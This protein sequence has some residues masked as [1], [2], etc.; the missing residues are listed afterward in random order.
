MAVHHK[1]IA[2]G[3]LALHPAITSSAEQALER[4][5][6][7]LT[8]SAAHQN[9]AQQ[10]Y[11]ERRGMTIMFSFFTGKKKNSRR[12]SGSD[13]HS[14]NPRKPPTEPEQL[15]YVLICSKC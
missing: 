15:V 10:R 11:V 8:V 9:A 7:K 5:I 6:K 2:G 1:Q 14:W 4:P 13:S 3:N 12:F